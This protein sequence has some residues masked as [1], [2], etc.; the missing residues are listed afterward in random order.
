MKAARGKRHLTYEEKKVKAKIDFS[1]ET[2][3]TKGKSNGIL[4]YFKTLSIYYIQKRS[5]SKM[6]ETQLLSQKKKKNSM[7][8]DLYLKKDQRKFLKLRYQNKKE[9]IRYETETGIYA[10]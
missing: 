7:L 9:R 4:K 8:E 2:M 6:N 1:S 3:Q 5:L 10:K